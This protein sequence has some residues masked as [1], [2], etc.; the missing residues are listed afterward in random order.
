MKK[1]I[2]LKIILLI[3]ISNISGTPTMHLKI[4]YKMAGHHILIG[5]KINNSPDTYNFIVDTGGMTFI[6]KKVADQLGLK[7]MGFQAK[8]NTLNISGQQIKKIFCLTTFDFKH[9]NRGGTIIH[10]IIGSDLMERYKVVFDFKSKL[11]VLSE[12]HASLVAGTGDIYIKFKNHPV[13]NAPVIKFKING[14]MIDGM[15]DTG[16]PYPVVLPLKD[17]EQHIRSNNSQYVKSRGLMV[18]WPMTTPRWNYL[19]RLNSFQVGNNKIKDLICVF[20]DLPPM[21]SM[22]LIGMEFLIQFKVIINYPKDEMVLVPNINTSFKNNKLSWGLNLSL[23]DKDEVLVEGIWESSPAHKS[24][25]A[26]GDRVLSFNSQKISSKNLSELIDSFHNDKIRILEIEIKNKKG[27]RK[28][29][30]IKKDL[31]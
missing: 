30:L 31:L 14:K 12:D 27:I 10:G 4:P 29:K 18:K 8:I 5:G 1:I 7:Q 23:S 15:V 26:V 25:I 21:L 17:F 3:L 6:D 24:N 19:T 28:I 11:I 16:Q 2:F 22:P 20:G 13:N 9:I